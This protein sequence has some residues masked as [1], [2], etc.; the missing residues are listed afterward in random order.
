[1]LRSTFSLAAATVLL[2]G[3][4]SHEYVNRSISALDAQHV[5]AITK[6]D[7]A[8]QA[9]AST[10]QTEA[11]AAHDRANAAYKLAEGK[12]QFVTTLS[13]AVNAFGAGRAE[14]S[15]T[16]QAS[17]TELAAKLMQSNQ[18]VY[19]EIQG[20][21]DNRGNEGSKFAIGQARAEAVRL[22]LNQQGVALNRMS[23]ISYSDVA[24]IASN[25]SE[26]GRAQN[27]RVVI[28]AVK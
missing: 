15:A 11:N 24:P 17:L 14:L 4:A 28:I 7:T 12:F 26:A 3:C 19:L 9:A 22:F 13:D 1:M 25:Q 2:S 16:A 18:D 5:A 23:A 6:V 27:R 21:T 20:H 8:A 10:A